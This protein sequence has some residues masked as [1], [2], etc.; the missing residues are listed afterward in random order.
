MSKGIGG[1]PHYITNIDLERRLDRHGS[2]KGEPGCDG[3]D[4]RDGERG[5]RGVPGAEGKQGKQGCPGEQGI[6]GKRGEPGIDGR[7]GCDGKD[8]KDGR[9]GRDGDQGPQGMPG[10]KGCD[11]KDGAPGKDGCCGDT[12]NT[13]LQG[14]KG[15]QGEPGEQGPPGVDGQKGDTGLTG[16][17]GPPGPQG[18]QGIPGEKG[19]T[20]ETGPQGVPGTDGANGMD[21]SVVSVQQAGTAT[22]IVVDGQPFIIQ[23]GGEGGL[24]QAQVQTLIDASNCCITGITGPDANGTYT[25]SQTNGSSYTFTVATGGGGGLTQAQV[26]ALIDASNC[27]ITGVTGPDAN[28][29]YTISQSNGAS[30][31]FT[32][33]STGCC[34]EAITSVTNADSS[35]TY[36]L[37]QSGGN[38]VTWTSP[39]PSSGGG[40]TA[41]EVKA[42]AQS[43]VDQAF[44]DASVRCVPT[45][46]GFEVIVVDVNGNTVI[47][48]TQPCTWPA[49]NGGLTEA[50]V[51]ALIQ[52][53]V[54]CNENVT[55]VTN[56]DGSITY[57]LPQSNGGSVT[58]TSPVPVTGG[59]AVT[60][61]VAPDPVNTCIDRGT[62]AIEGQA[63]CYF[64][65]YPDDPQ[66]KACYC[67]DMAAG[68]TLTIT[69]TTV[70]GF[71]VD[72]GENGQITQVAGGAAQTAT[73]QYTEAG[74]YC[75]EI[76]ANTFCDDL[77]GL[78][79]T[80]YTS[81]ETKACDGC[82]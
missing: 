61:T 55:Q 58:W 27:C 15:E 33:T 80:G 7:N 36:T 4:G 65:P 29:T 12:G 18:I 54:C 78:N 77:T 44:A 25:V 2:V 24:T 32:V 20:G 17:E 3:R 37:P 5:E 28:G 45:A 62:I 81:I 60:C 64:I 21:G 8:G 46:T 38:S 6:Q 82:S 70:D 43:C 53:Q 23:G 22:T 63:P 9:D 34:N 13:G 51:T 56:P 16:P 39:V 42:I 69:G 40:L 66:C 14:E 72:Q 49:D 19:E 57:T 11:G 79:I 52:A 59:S 26:Q 73:Y 30:F 76:I 41:S 48:S 71:S 67:V 35:I 47:E 68:A 74:T 75:I 31:P 10:P 1:K 50:Q